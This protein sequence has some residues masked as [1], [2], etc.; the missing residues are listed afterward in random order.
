M[1]IENCEI[2]GFLSNGIVIDI[3]SGTAQ[4]VITNTRVFGNGQGG[5]QVKPTGGS[6]MVSVRDVVTSGNTFGIG[7]DTTGGGSASVM[8]ERTTISDNSQ[9]GVQATGSNATLQLNNTEIQ[10][11]A[12][13]VNVTSPADVRS[14]KDNVIAQNSV[15]NVNGTLGTNAFQ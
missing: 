15:A 2:Y 1:L 13:G 3:S 7:L 4:V 10:H 14:F 5:I 12:T 9:S 11:N 6:T 8:V